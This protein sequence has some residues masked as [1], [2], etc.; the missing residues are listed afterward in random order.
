MVRQLFTME[1]MCSNVRG[2]LEKSQVDPDKVAIVRQA[3]LQIY[4]LGT[5]EKKEIPWRQ[6]TK[7]FDE[8]CRQLK[9]NTH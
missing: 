1:K 3:T 9:Q 8:S 2:K 5:G 6:Y 7:A 4:P